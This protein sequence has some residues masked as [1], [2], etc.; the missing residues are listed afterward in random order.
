MKTTLRTEITL[1]AAELLKE[2]PED[3]HDIFIAI[4]SEKL[5]PK[6]RV[7][8]NDNVLPVKSYPIMPDDPEK[9]MWIGYGVGNFES[10]EQ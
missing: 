8:V 5:D 1:V 3:A 6:A 7:L 2:V 10:F 4:H 9:T